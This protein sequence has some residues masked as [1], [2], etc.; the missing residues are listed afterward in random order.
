MD[1]VA[2]TV[3]GGRVVTASELSGTIRVWEPHASEPDQA[4]TGDAISLMSALALGRDGHVAALG[5]WEQHIAALDLLTGEMLGK[6]DCGAAVSSIAISHDGKRIAVS[7]GAGSVLVFDFPSLEPEFEVS[8]SALDPD[9][10]S[11]VS[12]IAP[13]SDE[14][15]PLAWLPD[16]VLVVGVADA[17][18]LIGGNGEIRERESVTDIDSELSRVAVDTSGVL[19]ALTDAG[20]AIWRGD[21]GSTT[22]A[23]SGARAVCAGA[24]RSDAVAAA[25]YRNPTI[26]YRHRTG[27]SLALH[28]HAGDVEDLAFSPDGDRLASVGEDG[29]LRLWDTTRGEALAKLAS[30]DQPPNAVAIARAAAVYATG[31][32]DGVVA[33]VD[34]TSGK[35]V[36]QWETGKR[37][38][39]L[40]FSPDERSLLYGHSRWAGLIDIAS[41]ET[42]SLPDGPA[43]RVGFSPDGTAIALA[44]KGSVRFLLADTLAVSASRTVD[45]DVSSACLLTPSELLVALL[46]GPVLLVDSRTQGN[47]R[48]VHAEPA[49]IAGGRTGLAILGDEDGRVRLL[50]GSENRRLEEI[51]RHRC[52]VVAVSAMSSGPLAATS[53]ESGL[54]LIWNVE[55]RE[56]VGWLQA[57]FIARWLAICD[58]QTVVAVSS[59]GDVAACA[60]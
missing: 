59:D 52:A 29:T 57:D 51:G 2:W 3:D 55:T 46:H 27:R 36:R 35:R 13:D 31:G 48:T 23:P 10:Y 60:P 21:E 6:V 47:P 12:Q 1:R 54:T 11:T 50:G 53:D 24:V 58:D 34:A 38:F 18:V 17:V 20:T 41:G 37:V 40:A 25:T 8:L 28:G 19:C 9:G 5:L 43:W 15:F 26:H 39:G 14:G 33:L 7:S 56:R 16:G 44:G 49:R 32:P 30:A 22:S 4:W 42:R 45:A